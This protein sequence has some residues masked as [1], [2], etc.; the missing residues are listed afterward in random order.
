MKELSSP[1]TFFYKYIF[2]L[3]WI[4]GFGLG[5]HEILLAGPENPKWIQ[6]ITIWALFASFIF[7]STGNVKKVT[8]YKKKIVVSN[9]LKTEEI[10]L[11]N[12]ESVD[13]STYL[14]PRLVWFNLKSSSGFGKKITFIPA[15]RKAKGIGKHPLVHELARDLEI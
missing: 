9:F 10:A 6:Y 2:I 3:I 13:G 14:S 15:I 7:F 11:S 8:M 4:V 1:F 5:T 12:I